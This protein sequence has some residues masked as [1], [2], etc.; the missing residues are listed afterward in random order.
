MARLGT[1]YL[2]LHRPENIFYYSAFNP[3]LFSHPL[4]VVVPAEGEP[5]LLL[6]SLRAGHAREE[7]GIG[8]I[9]SYGIWGRETPVA[10]APMDALE[11]LLTRRGLKGKKGGVEMDYLSAA[12]YHRLCA[13]LGADSLSDVSAAISHRKLVK[14]EHEIGMIRCASHIADCG[15]RFACDAWNGG[16]DEIEATSAAQTA[17]RNLWRKEYS[18]Y[19][20]AG[21]G[22]SEGGVVDALQAWCLAGPRIAWGTDCPRARRGEK[23]DL[24]QLNLWGKIAGYHAEIERTLIPRSAPPLL[25]KAYD[26]MLEGRQR[27]F[28]AI[29]P[30]VPMRELYH[31]GVSAYR[32]KGFGD[33]LPGRTGHGIGLSPHEHPSVAPDSDVVLESGMVFTVEPALMTVDWGGVR[34]S[35][36]VLVVP[37]GMEILTR[38]DRGK[39]EC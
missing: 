10:S 18:E 27:V 14:D 32:E 12:F 29:R 30:G 16:A 17:M 38:F 34:H 9:Y 20:T 21:F 19:E 24:V 2:L 4:F 28:D 1:D 23:G 11:E 3:I 35:D 8:E 13:V 22:S 6:H 39:L 31:L 7:A 15:C 33:I 36:T 25:H 26:A 5:F 37:G